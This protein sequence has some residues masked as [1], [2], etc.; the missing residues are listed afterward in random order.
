[1]RKPKEIR[2]EVISVRS[3]GQLLGT[4][5]AKDKEAAR[6]AAVKEFE[7]RAGEERSLIIRPV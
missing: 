4:V 1:V 5:Q 2:W 6:K 7:I 3:K